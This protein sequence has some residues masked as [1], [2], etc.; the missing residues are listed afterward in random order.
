MNHAFSGGR[1]KAEEQRKYG[2]EIDVDGAFC[3]A[4]KD[5]STSML[6]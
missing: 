1:D 6:M 5:G 2:A 3:V 4:F